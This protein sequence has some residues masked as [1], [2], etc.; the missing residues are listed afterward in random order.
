MLQPG[1]IPA[2]AVVEIEDRNRLRR[3]LSRIAFDYVDV[4]RYLLGEREKMI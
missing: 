3:R 2:L 4:V 1:E